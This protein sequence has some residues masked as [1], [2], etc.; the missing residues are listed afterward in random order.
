L[1]PRKTRVSAI[2]AKRHQRRTEGRPVSKPPE[3][4]GA[5]NEGPL[6][7]HRAGRYREPRSSVRSRRVRLPSIGGPLWAMSECLRDRE[8][9]PRKLVP[10]ARCRPGQ[11]R[12]RRPDLSSGRV[13]DPRGGARRKPLAL[14]GSGARDYRNR[15]C[16]SAGRPATDPASGPRGRMLMVA[17]EPGRSQ[18]PGRLDAGALACLGSGAGIVFNSRM[19]D[20]LT[21]LFP[22]GG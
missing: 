16:P 9:P 20:A 17:V 12:F 19:S 10:L 4:R 2:E 7:H 22:M 14:D 5:D 13:S 8:A 15:R 18:G 3:S 6:M 1:C 11:Q 21:D